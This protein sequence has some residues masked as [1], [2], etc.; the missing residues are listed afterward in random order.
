[1]SFINHWVA[2]F[3]DDLSVVILLEV[4]EDVPPMA[5]PGGRTSW[6]LKTNVNPL[7]L[8]NPSQYSIEGLVMGSFLGSQLGCG[9]KLWSV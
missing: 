3:I 5:K 9:I 1:V 4:C 8:H 2:G 7:Q 6:N